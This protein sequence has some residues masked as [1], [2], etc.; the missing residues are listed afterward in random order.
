MKV[1]FFVIIF[2]API[3]LSAQTA[4]A[5]YKVYD[6]TQQKEISLDDIV[7]DAKQANVIFFGEDHNNSICH[8]VEYA[9]TRKFLASYPSNVT[10][11]MEMFRTDLQPVL[12]EYLD[13]LISERNLLKEG[14]PWP[15]YKDYK[16][17][18]DYAKSHHMDI[19]AANLAA[20]YSNAV[21]LDGLSVLRRFPKASKKFLP[22]LPIDTAIGRYLE[23]FNETVGAHSMGGMKIYQTQ[24]LWDASIAWAIS[25]YLK[26]HPN[27]KILQLN[28]RFHSDEFLGAVARL[29]LYNRKA[30]ILTVSSF[31]AADFWRPNWGN[32]KKLA[33]YVILTNPNISR[34]Y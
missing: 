21:T 14:D 4:D 17:M 10:L 31:P 11:S 1:A 26:K 29:K 27:R 3:F 25:K 13:G 18:V 16:P 19:I 22:P 7:E 12:D 6:V 5:L 28:G 20:R 8:A 15:N 23:K 30:K 34:T 32:Y 2:L 33:D 9:L 24:N